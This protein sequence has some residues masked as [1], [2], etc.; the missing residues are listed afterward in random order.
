M[1]LFSPFLDDTSSPCVSNP[2]RRDLMNTILHK[3][4]IFAVILDILIEKV[5]LFWYMLCFCDDLTFNYLELV[6]MNCI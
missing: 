6:L 5:K 3:L 2:Y 1:I 4:K